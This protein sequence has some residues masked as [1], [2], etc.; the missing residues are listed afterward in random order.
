MMHPPSS[1][2]RPRLAWSWREGRFMQSDRS[3]KDLNIGATDD[4]SR[5]H[6]PA[7]SLRQPLNAHH[8]AAHSHRSATSGSTFVARRAG[9]KQASRATN[10]NS[11]AITVNVSGS[12]GLTLYSSVFIN[13]VNAKEALN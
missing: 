8:S 11:N 12:V 10:A 2:R 13:R 5:V 3:D 6:R 9:T 1:C 4:K 7:L